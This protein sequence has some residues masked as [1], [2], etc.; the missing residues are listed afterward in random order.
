MALCRSTTREGKPCPFD[1]RPSG[2]CHVHDPEVQCGAPLRN[3][4]RCSAPTG[5]KR[6]PRHADTT[7][8][9]A[10]ALDEAARAVEAAI[11]AGVDRRALAEAVRPALL[12]IRDQ[13]WPNAAPTTLPQARS[14]RGEQKRL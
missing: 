6:C 11:A 12:R 3:G 8:D 13:V 1:A 2:L 4:K 7:A 14:T 5:G 10:A 9:V